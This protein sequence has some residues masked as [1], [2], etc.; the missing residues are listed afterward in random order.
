MPEI[1]PKIAELVLDLD[2]PRF[3]TWQHSSHVPWVLPGDR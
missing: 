3:L 2:H 1:K